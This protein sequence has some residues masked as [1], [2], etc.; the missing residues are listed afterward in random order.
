MSA[1]P[2]IGQPIAIGQWVNLDTLLVVGFAGNPAQVVEVKA[3]SVV[4]QEAHRLKFGVVEMDNPRVRRLNSVRFV[5]D[6]LAQAEAIRA[7]SWSFIERELEIERELKAKAQQRRK[8]A[9]AQVLATLV[10]ADGQGHDLDASIPVS[11]MCA[12]APNQ[13]L[14]M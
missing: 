13:Q 14:E 6:T 5:C 3:K 11:T 12:V 2:Y 10:E 9:V 8:Q 7:A 4:V 1:R